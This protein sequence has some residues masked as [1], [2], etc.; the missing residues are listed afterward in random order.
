MNG[1]TVKILNVS[2]EAKKIIEKIDST[3]L[4][5]LDNKNC[6]RMELFLFALALGVESGIETELTKTD[7]LVR[8]EYLSTK[9]EAYL[10]SVFISELSDSGD[11]DKIN[12]IG[13]VYR[14]A[15]QYANTGFKLI[16]GMME[17]AE[18]VVQ[19]ELLQE[20]DEMYEEYAI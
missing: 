7:T 19:L 8:A 3:K 10:Y 5:N 2:G 18:N 11:L 15:Q 4:L 9:N 20:L 14:K 1:N 6:S 17:K 12:D 16:E 13:N